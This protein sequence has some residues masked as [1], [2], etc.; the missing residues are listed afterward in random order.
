MKINV[1]KL[2]KK[3]NDQMNLIKIKIHSLFYIKIS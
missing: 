1:I 2:V 3:M